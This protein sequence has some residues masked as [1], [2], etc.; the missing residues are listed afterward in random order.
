MNTSSS[1][2]AYLINPRFGQMEN[3]SIN[4]E[5]EL[6]EATTNFLRETK[7]QVNNPWMELM[8]EEKGCFKSTYT[9]IEER[10]RILR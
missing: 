10:V 3:L 2:F 6:K 7:N 9:N 8:N 5:N 4:Y 1:I